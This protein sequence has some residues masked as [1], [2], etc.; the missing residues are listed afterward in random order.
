[1][2]ERIKYMHA[3]V[4]FPKRTKI[5]YANTLETSD[6]LHFYLLYMIYH[7]IYLFMTQ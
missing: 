5:C 3:Q 7:Y 4:K 2:I 1:M 6:T